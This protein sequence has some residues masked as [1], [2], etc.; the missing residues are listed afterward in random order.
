MADMYSQDTP[1]DEEFLEDEEQ[2]L[3]PLSRIEELMRKQTESNR[4]L[5]ER[6]TGRQQQQQAPLQQEVEFTLEGLPDPREDINA[7]NAGL[8]KRLK[9]LSGTTAN[10]VEQRVTAR[11]NEQSR[12]NIAVSRTNDLVREANPNL[13]DE[14]IG[15]IS[16]VVAARMKAAGKDP[17]TEILRS[18]DDVAQQIVDYADDMARQVRGEQRRPN[19]PGR[20]QV[21]G[22]GKG[23]GNPGRQAATRRTSKDEADPLALV[24]DIQEFQRK[25]RY[26]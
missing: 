24:R 7:F 15:A 21:L 3:D 14:T 17:K 13:N 1:R 26:Y 11:V 10:A 4:E 9:E 12:L 22:R 19:N 6:V 2:E 5:I 23:G 25:G 18:A 16:Q 8:G 20:A